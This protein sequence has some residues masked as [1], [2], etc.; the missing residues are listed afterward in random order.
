MHWKILLVSYLQMILVTALKELL[1][2]VNIYQND[3]KK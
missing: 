2:S 1:N 3:I